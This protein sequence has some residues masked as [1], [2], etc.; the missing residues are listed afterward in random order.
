MSL[1]NPTVA[2]MVA[3]DAVQKLGPLA[4]D[5]FAKLLANGES[6]MM[7]AM[8]VTRTP[9]RLG[10]TDDTMRKGVGGKWW[11]GMSEVSAYAWNAEYRKRTGEN[12]PEGAVILRSFAKGIGDHEVVLTHKHGLKDIQRVLR[13]RNVTA[14]GDGW[15]VE[16]KDPELKPQLSRIAPDL[17]EGLRQEYIKDD[18]ALAHKDQQELREMIVEKHGSPEVKDVPKQCGKE[19]F[20]ALSRKVWQEK[21]RITVSTSPSRPAGDGTAT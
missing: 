1:E 20:A 17:V 9:P 18:P 2:E 16:A 10:I 13:E 5:W 21:R 11:E 14:Y 12:I 6:I 7:A 3:Y 15:E 8:L 4:I 19:A